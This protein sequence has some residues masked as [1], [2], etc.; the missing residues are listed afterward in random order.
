M[1]KEQI[2]TLPYAHSSLLANE[3]ESV[4]TNE[5]DISIQV[6]IVYSYQEYTVTFNQL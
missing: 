4:L 3:P 6:H 1:A 5:P 2:A